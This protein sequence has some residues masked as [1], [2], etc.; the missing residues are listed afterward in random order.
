MAMTIIEKG[1]DYSKREIYELTKSPKIQKMSEHVGEQLPVDQYL[2]YEDGENKDVPIQILSIR[3]GETVV[4]TNS[5]TV[6][7]EFRDIV[8]LMDGEPFAVEILTGTSKNGRTY[9][10][11]ALA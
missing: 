8:E 3:S 6:I 9:L 4:A 2:L 1:G 5:A 11:V 10:T 7:K